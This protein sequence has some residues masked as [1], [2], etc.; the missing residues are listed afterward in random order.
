VKN[1][2]EEAA[3]YGLKASIYNLLPPKKRE[4][5]LQKD[6]ARAKEQIKLK[7]VTDEN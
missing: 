1:L 7:G 4:T 6:I 2:Y 3:K 5:A